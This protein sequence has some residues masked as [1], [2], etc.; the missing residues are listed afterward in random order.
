MILSGNGKSGFALVILISSAC[1]NDGASTDTDGA[2]ASSSSSTTSVTASTGTSGN[3]NSDSVTDSTA[4]T[5]SG[6]SATAGTNPT[7][8]VTTGTGSTGATTEPLTSGPSTD[9]ASTTDVGTTSD[10]TT[11]DSTTGTTG[12]GTT[13]DGT[14]GTTGDGTTG[15]G[16]TGD[17][18]TGDPIV[19]GNLEVVYRDFKPLHVDFGCHMFGN[20]AR[21]G[22]VEPLI[23]KDQKPVFNANLPAPPGNW[24]GSVPQITS[25]QSFSEWYNTKDGTNVAVLGELALMEIKPGL[26]SFASNSF[27]PLTDKGFGNNVTPNWANAT[28][29]DRN[30]SF[31]TEIHT[32][33]L[34]EMGQVFNFQGDDDVWVFIDGKLAMDLGGLHPSVTGAINLDTL[35]LVPG[36]TYSLDV[37]HAERCESG[38]NFRIDTSINC[39]IPM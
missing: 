12:D 35:G 17:G 7:E 37:F 38:S 20:I 13:S 21:P 1:G 28:F 4:G 29:P 9:T 36:E 22:L 14:T 31:T 18:T 2:S 19:C 23:G 26:W 30:G 25:A 10:G 34:Y 24:N 11:G 3:S 5:D 8:A 27:Y 15:D 39:F 32:S 33:F 6:N 16:T